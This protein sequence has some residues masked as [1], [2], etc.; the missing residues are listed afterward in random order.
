MILAF[1][2]LAKGLW[3]ITCEFNA[4]TRCASFQV[5]LYS[6]SHKL[7]AAILGAADFTGIGCY[8]R[9]KRGTKT[10]QTFCIGAVLRGQCQDNRFCTAC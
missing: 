1:V 6:V 10:L 9:R 3:T 4:T 5:V 8:R 7:D 2:V